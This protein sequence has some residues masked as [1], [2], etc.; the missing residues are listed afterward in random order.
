MVGL[1]TLDVRKLGYRCV[2]E[3]GKLGKGHEKL[4]V[5]EQQPEAVL[6]D[7]RD[8]NYQNPP[9]PPHPP[10]SPTPLRP[11]PTLPAPNRPLP[12]TPFPPFTLPLW[13]AHPD[14][15]PPH[16]PSHPSMPTTF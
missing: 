12:P 7:A 1:R 2:L 8:F 13:L 14:S 16:P 3:P 11:P 5:P 10:P 4:L 6:R 9:A 15:P